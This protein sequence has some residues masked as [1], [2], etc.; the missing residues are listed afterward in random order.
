M[1]N[2]SEAPYR[3]TGLWPVSSASLSNTGTG[4][5]A[6]PDTSSRADDNASA[7]S[8]SPTTRDHTVGTP[9]YSD[10]WAAA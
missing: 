4:S 6:L 7:A 8:R 5:A 9:K 3:S 2:V 1:I 10:P